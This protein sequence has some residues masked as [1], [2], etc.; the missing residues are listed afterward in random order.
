M[1]G[2]LG[3]FHVLAV[4]NSA[5]VKIEVHVHFLSVLF[6]CSRGVYSV[7]LVSCVQQVIQLYI[8]SFFLKWFSRIGYQRILSRVPCD[9]R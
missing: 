2:H 7:V 3:C 1:N 4:L 8:Y 5:A 9:I 6:Y